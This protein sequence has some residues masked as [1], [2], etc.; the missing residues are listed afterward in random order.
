MLTVKRYRGK[1]TLLEW[2]HKKTGSLCRRFSITLRN[3]ILDELDFKHN[4]E[5]LAWIDE[6]GRIVIEKM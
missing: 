6:E 4:D 5:V 1:V 3:K 2:K